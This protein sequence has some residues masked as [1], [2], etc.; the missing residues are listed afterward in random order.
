MVGAGEADS[1]QEAAAEEVGRLGAGVTGTPTLRHVH[2]E[3][4]RSTQDEVLDELANADGGAIV[5]VSCDRQI[6][7]RG[8]EGR[9]WEQPPCGALLVSVGIRGPLPAAVLQELPRRVA[10]AVCAVVDPTASLAD[11]RVAWKAP[12]DLVDVDGAKLG[13]I[14]VDARTTG[15]SVDHVVVGIGINARG[16]RFTTSDGRDATTL[17]QVVGAQAQL[18]LLRGRVVDAV[19]GE[20][21]RTN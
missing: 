11:P 6:D 8:R 4:C 3:A 5:A 2:L 13:G 17:E 21:T 7:G 9:R 15:S 18:E 16:E 1:A 20:L 10:R 19:A 14:L 12:N